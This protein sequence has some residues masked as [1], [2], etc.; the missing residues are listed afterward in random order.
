M[1]FPTVRD[2]RRRFSAALQLPI[3]A[4]ATLFVR[5]DGTLAHVEYGAVTTRELDDLVRTHLRTAA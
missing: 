5:A 1:T 3:G 4:P 2:D